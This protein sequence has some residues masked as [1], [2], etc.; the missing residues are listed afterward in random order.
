MNINKVKKNI[1]RKSDGERFAKLAELDEDIFHAN[2][3]GNL[4]GIVKKTTLY[5]TLSRYLKRGLLFRV[6]N[7]LYSIK[8]VADIN[9]Y[10]LGIKALHRPAYISC[11]S[12]LYKNGVLNQIPQAITL[13]SAVSKVFSVGDRRYKSRQMKDEYLFNNI[14]V[15]II[16]GVREATLSR[17]VAD[18]LYFNPKKYFDAGDSKMINWLEVK[19]IVRSVGYKID[20]SRF[21]KFKFRKADLLRDFRTFV[22]DQVNDRVLAENLNVLLPHSKFAKIRK[23][24][25][26]EVL[27]CLN[28]EIIRVRRGV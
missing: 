22:D 14:G 17:A 21:P 15:E 8:K 23:V 4:W 18:M 24:L 6:H 27:T 10:L 26:R 25:K 11:E 2:D 28:D 12:V 19:E 5:Q 7:G 3:L 20:Q 9:P 16:N 13:I 1:T